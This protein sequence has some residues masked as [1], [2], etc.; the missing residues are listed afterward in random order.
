MSLTANTVVLLP[1]A[2]RPIGR[3]IAKRFALA[4]CRLVM[5]VFDWP[6]SVASLRDEFPDNN[7][8]WTPDCDLRSPQQVAAL[9]TGISERFAGL[10]ILINN[11]E[12]GGMPVVHGSYDLPVNAGQWQ[13][14]FATTLEAKRL[15][16]AH[17]LPLLRRNAA[18]AVVNISSI[19]ARCGRHGAAAPFFSDG[20]SLANRAIQGLTE[21]WAR[22]A[23]P[24]VRVNELMLGFIASRHGE[25]TR[26]WEALSAAERAALDH[27]TP[28]GRRGL[29]EEVAEAVYFLAMQATYM[30][31]AVVRMD[32]GYMLGGE[33]TPPLPP[34]I[35]PAAEHPAA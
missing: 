14:E 4:G 21:A 27:H 11:I 19:A 31:G 24:A 9:F 22:Q 5:P 20:Y 1:G 12:R 15:L 32:G 28:L 13:R 16:F 10:G 25:G 8:F 35:L 34:G 7:L 6:Q 30:T 33:E 29:P 3:A 26:G 17:A 18:A 2:A 23:A